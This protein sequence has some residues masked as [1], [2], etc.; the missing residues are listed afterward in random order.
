MRKLF[1]LIPALVLAIVTNAAIPELTK[2]A[3]LTLTAASEGFSQSDNAKPLEDGE[4]INW[5][6]GTIHEGFAKWNVNIVDPGVYSVTLDMKCDN[7]YK[8]RACV[9][10]PATGDTIAVGRSAKVDHG[11]GYANATEDCGQ[12]NLFAR[13]AGEYI[14]AVTD[15]IKWSEG[16]VRG[17]TLIYLNGA[18]INM[19][20]TLA[21]ANALLSEAAFVNGDGELRFTD[22]DHTGNILTQYGM[23]SVY[24]KGGVYSFTLNANSTNSH[25]YK[26][27]VLNPDLSLVQDYVLDGS[28]N[29]PLTATT[30][31]IEL[32]KGNYIVK[33]Q[34]TTQYSTGRVINIIANYNGGA[35]VDI[36]VTLMPEDALL[37]A[38]AWV[39][40]TGAVD[41]ILFTPRG[42]EGY[43]PDEWAKWKINVSKAGK[44]KFTANVSSSNGQ[45]YKIS[46]LNSDETEIVGEKDGTG[47]SL[48]KGDKT[49]ATDPIELAVG[50]YVIKIVNTYA[51]SC[52]RVRNI[53]A[54]YEGGAVVSMPGTLLPEDAILSDRAWVDNT[55]AVDSILFTPRGSEG[56]NPE[57]WAKWK[58]NVTKAGM[59][60]FMANVS[61]SNGQYYKISVLNSDETVTVGEKDGT[62]TSLSKG[63]KTF[64]TDPIELAVGEYVVKIV[65]TYAYSKGRVLNI[66]AT[67]E[68]GALAN[69]PGQILGVDAMLLK[70]DGGTL[71]MYHAANGDITYNDNGDPTTEYAL[72]NIHADAACELAVELNIATSGHILTVELYDGTTLLGSAAETEATKWDGGNIALEDH[73]NIP[74][75]GNYTIK[76]INSQQWSHGALHGITFTEIVPPTVV[77]LDEMAEDNSAWVA[78]VGGDPVNVQLTRTFKGGVYNSI[79]VPFAASMSKIKAA[80]GDDVVLKYLSE[81]SLEGDM[82]NLVFE[83]AQDFYQGTPYLI[84][85]SADV[86]NPEF[87]GVELLAEEGDATGTAAVD[88]IGTFVKK[89]VAA[90]ANNLY[91]G[92]DNKLYFSE[93]AVTIKGLRAY[94]HVK[95]P[96]AAQAI[97]HARIVTRENTATAI[98]FVNGENKAIKRIENG[99]VVILRDGIRYNVMG[100]K[101]Q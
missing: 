70:E 82:L 78:N 37:S 31:N 93:N 13:E 36:P 76:V 39:D 27:S 1:L 61:S 32:A 66:V 19:P 38:R 100:I 40:K 60:K 41:S 24:S 58:I 49:F 35:L 7:T 79:C 68:G 51:Y 25:H 6:G 28:S 9:I 33:I 21:P 92:M 64:A 57:E 22:D 74:A 15:T 10:N 88:F 53:V 14:I 89:E 85:P 86:V 99:Q 55:G 54:K 2:S 42:S 56:H 101:L 67:Y 71:K 83:D 98:D 45:Y 18:T 97:K 20:E 96:G 73:L 95:V 75:A 17:M 26:L 44:Y 59:Y 84:M 43:N 52:G 77:V 87:E 65:N 81:T 63:D 29:T 30:A 4:W 91:L 46:I 62:G 11:A 16:K 5:P 47:T 48:S 80:F 34:N 50:E 12:F 72:W 90:N 69:V 3:P 23:W 8:F 94:F